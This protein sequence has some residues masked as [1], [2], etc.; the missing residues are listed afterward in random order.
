MENL[1]VLSEEQREIAIRA[2]YVMFCRSN[3][4]S[5]DLELGGERIYMGKSYDDNLIYSNIL[6]YNETALE[7]QKIYRLL[8]RFVDSDYKQLYSGI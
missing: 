8:K 4:W 2:A 1:P 3:N 7:D 5:S 6:K